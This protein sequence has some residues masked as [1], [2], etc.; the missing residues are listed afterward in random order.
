M[1]SQDSV[2]ELAQDAVN[3]GA[4]PGSVYPPGHEYVVLSQENYQQGMP[5]PNQQSND[6][7]NQQEPNDDSD[8]DQDQDQSNDYSAPP[9]NY[10]DPP[11]DNNSEDQY[12]AMQSEAEY[13]ATHSRSWG[14]EG[15]D[16][17]EAMEE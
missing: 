2:H 11:R 4:L 1:D 17:S 5:N 6:D 15:I 9:D 10:S 13:D 14:D 7:P 8:Q 12:V 16:S 3:A